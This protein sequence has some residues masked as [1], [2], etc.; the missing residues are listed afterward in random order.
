MCRVLPVLALLVLTPCADGSE[1]IIRT[2]VELKDFKFSNPTKGCLYDLTGIITDTSPIPHFT[3]FRRVVV[4]DE[5]GACCVRCPTDRCPPVGV[6]ARLRGR[7]YPQPSEWTSTVTRS[8]DV[9]GPAQVPPPVDATV[10]QLFDEALNY[11]LVRVSGT[12]VE[13]L[14]DEIDPRDYYLVLKSGDRFLRIS[15]NNSQIPVEDAEQFIDAEIRVTGMSDPK[16]KMPDCLHLDGFIAHH[17][18][19]DYCRRNGADDRQT[20]LGKCG[21]GVEVVRRECFSAG[22][23]GTA[24]MCTFIAAVIA[25][26]V[27]KA[28]CMCTFGPAGHTNTVYEVMRLYSESVVS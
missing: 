21:A 24:L 23:A 14:P 26:S 18:L 16:G 9:L 7:I 15:V 28:A 17:E 10:D 3:Q 2:A 6:T 27:R 5:S 8:A 13:I 12:V 4:L 20:A 25:L 11:R 19:P 1:R 22:I